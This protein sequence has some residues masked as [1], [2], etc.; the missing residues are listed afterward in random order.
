SKPNSSAAIPAASSAVKRGGVDSRTE[1]TP[2]DA[3]GQAFKIPHPSEST[4]P[5]A[6]GSLPEGHL[7]SGDCLAATSGR[8]AAQ[9]GRDKEVDV[10]AHLTKRDRFHL[11][12][13]Q[14]GLLT[15]LLAMAFGM[16]RSGASWGS[17]VYD[18]AADSY[19]MQNITAADGTQA[20]L[21]S[22]YT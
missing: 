13:W 14:A 12:A 15:V 20:W 4:P 18:P 8:S 7:L 10:G 16:V 19:S 6:G 9:G 5:L 17:S 2:A 21:S 3:N 1:V 22:G 11:R